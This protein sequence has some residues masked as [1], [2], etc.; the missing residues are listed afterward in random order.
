MGPPR[1]LDD[2]LSHIVVP[3]DIGVD[4]LEKLIEDSPWIRS[5]RKYLRDRNLTDDENILKFIIMIKPLKTL[6]LNNNEVKILGHSKLQ[7]GPSITE[8]EARRL[9]LTVV[10]TF[11]SEESEDILPF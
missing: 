7:Q 10:E 5:F 4:D 11:L 9:F 1:S 3:V 6:S 2:L 8:E